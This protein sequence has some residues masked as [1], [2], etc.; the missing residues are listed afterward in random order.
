MIHASQE[1][2][3]WYI[4][5]TIRKE[6]SLCLKEKGLTQK[7]VAGILSLT[8]AAVSQ[9]ISKKRADMVVLSQ[10]SRENI[11]MAADR[12]SKNPKLLRIEIARIMD[13]IKENGTLCRLHKSIGDGIPSDCR[14][15]FDDSDIKGDK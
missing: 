14:I 11:K 4:L 12:I 9:Y 13:D 10:D 8:E 2:E 3:V 7:K 6:L 5:P 15:C 1:I